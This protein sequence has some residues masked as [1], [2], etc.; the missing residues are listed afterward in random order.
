MKFKV[1][2]II[3]I[4][5]SGLIVHIDE[6]YSSS[7]IDSPKKQINHGIKFEDIKCNDRLELVLKYS[8]GKPVCI[9]YSSI[10][11]LIDRNWAIEF[12]LNYKK[13][14]KTMSDF[15]LE[16]KLI[17][18]KF[19]N[20]TKNSFDTLCKSKC[21]GILMGDGKFVDSLFGNAIKFDG[22]GWI[23]IPLNDEM[24]ISHENG[25][26]IS[27]WVMINS[28]EDGDHNIIFSKGTIG[29]GCCYMKTISGYYYADEKAFQTWYGGDNIDEY[30]NVMCPETP[31]VNL[32][33]W[34]HVVYVLN[35]DNR[36]LHQ[37]VN[38]KIHC[39]GESKSAVDP[40]TDDVLYLGKAIS[41][42]GIHMS[43]ITLDNFS[44]YN[45]ALDAKK[46]GIIFD[47]H[48]KSVK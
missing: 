39:S 19:E 33:E 31:D 37:Y 1:Y 16:H 4:L 24:N 7:S 32:N 20:D 14:S 35:K 26:S 5:F 43:H 3:L 21:D 18:F 9:K 44:V 17:S 40:V 27:F 10:K 46:V 42:K 12:S 22:N 23:E 41:K 6:I 48:L 11:K 30:L 25:T 34:Y 38:G 36:T 45:Y 29:W 2:L 13:T 8:N 15:P 47:T 28:H